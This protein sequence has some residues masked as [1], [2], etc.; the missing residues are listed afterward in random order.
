MDMD[1]VFA[2]N[3]VVEFKV[4]DHNNGK[5]SLEL[6]SPG[7]RNSSKNLRLWPPWN[8]PSGFQASGQWNN[9]CLQ[10]IPFPVIPLSTGQPDTVGR[11]SSS[12]LPEG[13]LKSQ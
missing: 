5:Q 12:L 10:K 4:K 9:F 6:F 1:I 8:A 2:S 13:F 7:E 3:L 11:W